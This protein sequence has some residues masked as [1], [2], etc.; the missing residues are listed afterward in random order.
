M[1][2][3]TMLKTHP[4]D[5]GVDES[6]LADTLASLADCAQVCTACADACLAEEGV[7]DLVRC[8]RT[9]LDCADVCTAT[10][11][12][13]SR[14]TQRDHELVRALLEACATACDICSSECGKHAEMHEHCRVC[15][16]VCRRCS[17]ACRELAAAIA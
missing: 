7:A 13:A 3:T 2:H 12:V 1:T 11:A 9:D 10:L 5:L 15:S 16:E 4:G 6:L 14:Q 8:I 17:L